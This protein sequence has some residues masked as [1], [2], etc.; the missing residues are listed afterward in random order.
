MI[1]FDYIDKEDMFDSHS[2]AKGG[3]ILHMLRHYLG[4]DAFYN[5]LK[6]YLNDNA[7]NSV[8]IHQLR[9]AMEAI[10]GEDLNWF[11]NQWFLA[12]GHPKLVIDYD[13]DNNKKQ[14]IVN[15]EQIQDQSN[16]NIYRLPF[17]IDVYVDGKAQR[18]LMEMNQKKQK[19]VFNVNKEPSNVIVDAEHMLL[20]EIFDEKSDESWLE[21]MNAPLYMD[22]KIALENISEKSS[23][24]A[25]IQ[26]LKSDFWGIRLIGIKKASKL[27]NNKEFLGIIEQH[28]KNEENTKVK[29]A[30]LRLLSNL[31]N[32]NE[33]LPLLEL[34][35]KE[36]S[37]LVAGSGLRGLA[38][39]DAEK[40]LALAPN[41][42]NDLKNVVNE[43][44][45]NYGGPDKAFYFQ[46]LFLNSSG[47][48]LYYLTRDYTK[49]LKNQ[50]LSVILNGTLVLEKASEDAKSWMISVSQYYLRD[51]K[52]TITEL[53][54]I[55]K[56]KELKK[57]ANETLERIEDLLK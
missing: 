34:A 55:E 53:Y 4:D 45:A 15:I 44:Y 7:Y 47:Y 50:E 1:R 3:R 57:K 26:A 13:Y 24:Q 30:A 6:K 22:S 11:F 41:F 14:Q 23:S 56:N 33:Y 2:Y 36:Q 51:I 10:S 18:H 42:E 29:S 54:K 17:A 39:L 38:K 43:I 20:A 12:S 32:K 49:F 46:K 25:V 28:A 9:I 19:F 5:G 40:A 48:D 35:T 16:T 52:S 27:K 8:E 37:L 21:Q 31:D